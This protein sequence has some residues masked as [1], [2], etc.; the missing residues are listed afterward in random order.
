MYSKATSIIASM[1]TL[2]LLFF[3]VNTAYAFQ[4]VEVSGTVT[5]ASSGETLPG[6]NVLL[7]GTESGTATDMNGR[8]VLSISESEFE[9]G[10]L[11]FSSIG[12]ETEE[13]PI[14]G[15]NTVNVSMSVQTLSGGE[16]V[17]VGYG[18]QERR[19]ITGSVSSVQEE[20]F[21]SG[22][23]K[24]VSEMI[25]GKVPGLQV[26]TAAGGNPN[27]NATIR[28]RG[29]NSFGANQEPL[30]VVDGIIGADLN[31]IDPNDISS[32][33]VLKDASA[34]AIYGTRG[35]AGVI[36]I[37]TKSGQ[38]GAESLSVNY[39]GYTT[40]ET[41]EN[42][43]EV[44]SADEY[45]SFSQETG[46]EIQDFGA[47]TDWFDEISQ[48]GSNQVH[49][50]AI[51]GGT[52]NMNYRLSGNYRD[53]EGIQKHTGFEQLGA[54][55]N[56]THWSL[57]QKLKLT[58][59]I[60]VTNRDESLGFGDAFR[61][62]QIMNPTAPVTDEGFETLAGYFDQDLF[63]YYNPV[64]II[65]TGE[66]LEETKNF[67][68]AFKAD[69][70]F[71]DLIPNLRASIFYSID[72]EDEVGRAFYNKNNKLQ[73]SA[74]Q[75]S[76]GRGL[77]QQYYNDEQNE[78][79][80]LTVNYLGDLSERMSIEAFAG[81]SY[82]EEVNEGFSASGGDFVTD[83]VAFN[84][85]GFAQDFDAGTGS[86]GS[87]RNSNKIIGFFSRVNLNFDDTYFLNASIR[88]EGSSRFGVD[89]KWGN[90]WSLGGGVQVSNLVD[91]G[92]LD[93][94]RLRASIGKTGNNAPE[95]GIAT[96]RFGPTGGN[97]FANGN[98]IQAFGPVSNANPELKWEEKTEINIGADIEALDNRIRG[99]VE[100]YN[101]ITSDLLYE[102]G[103]PVPP[104]LFG[105]TWRNVG[106]MENSGFEI[107]AAFEAIQSTTGGFNWSTQ[108]NFTIFDETMLNKFESDEV[109][110]IATAGS[111]GQNS[112][113]LIRIKEGEPI[114]QIWG[115]EF[116]RIGPD[117]NWL[118]LDADGNEVPFGDLNQD[119]ERLLGNGLPDYQ[120][121]WTN[122]FNYGNWDMNVFFQGS[123]GH[124][125][126]NL[127]GLFYQAP[128]Q[129]ASYNVLKSAMDVPELTDSPQYSS[130]YV[131][132]ADYLRLQNMS[133]GYTVPLGSNSQ[134]DRL[135]LY[136][137]G[138]H[139][140][141][142]TDYSGI[143]PEV[144]HTDGNPGIL[145]TG[146]TTGGALAPG[147]ERRS[148]WFT[149]RSIN[150]G[151]NLSF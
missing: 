111:P 138:N 114:G 11:V 4:E 36:L 28:L 82:N 43:N 125:L 150:L 37:T 63:D 137:S 103:V 75:S 15:Q 106:E 10:V 102:V 126:V 128:R 112:T 2:L 66:R 98:F 45:R 119:D 148:N 25:Q 16:L 67:T 86:V 48:N 27:S 78:L 136:V 92:F 58:G 116:S 40:F 123:F 35:S 7:Q 59:N 110:Y 1:L 50:L 147:I 76:L 21:V 20:D 73:G 42:K 13:V 62:A 130:F 104:N 57:D 141:T 129:M 96:Q 89:N 74:T 107:S 68:A 90:F 46:F 88:R 8:F 91:L 51:S 70:E 79:F 149:T 31:N 22:N 105:R 9:N 109:R 85:L 143:N 18:I 64:N 49:S 145:T 61:Y 23:V 100:Y 69:Y 124:Q 53:R 38:Q 30:I 117:G 17:V 60:A 44:L 93:E 97:F 118:F 113:D 87:Y 65:E 52:E 71:R 55:L 146:F 77:A 134:I 140:F 81:Y 121:G 34:S 54:R 108:V 3:A 83:A 19:Q 26:S 99:S 135:R 84:N 133:I 122:S 132:D 39:N 127:F 151:V 142:I 6:V 56:L 24:D 72:N 80:E 139:L 101:S 144:R 41:I 47:S 32:V 115:P 120:I 33:D 131:E 12:F 29:I 14:D 5:D 95:S 94:L